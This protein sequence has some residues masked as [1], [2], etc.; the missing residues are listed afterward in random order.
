VTPQPALSG[1]SLSTASRDT[2]PNLK[3]M[4]R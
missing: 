3:R 4:N 1:R 2:S